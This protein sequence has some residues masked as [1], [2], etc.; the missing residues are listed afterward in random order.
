MPEANNDPRPHEDVRGKHLA[1]MVAIMLEVD[2]RCRAAE[3]EFGVDAEFIFEECRLCGSGRRLT[4]G[5]IM[6]EQGLSGDYQG[7]HDFLRNTHLRLVRE[8]FERN[9]AWKFWKRWLY[10]PPTKEEEEESRR[11]ALK[12]LR[13][14][15]DDPDLES[16]MSRRTRDHSKDW[17]RQS[18]WSLLKRWFKHHV[19]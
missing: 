8:K 12:V 4:H 19:F 13:M 14:L 17:M 1:R 16:R 7:S 5:E 2:D 3:N 18:T 6:R 11:F 15:V 10:L 9:N